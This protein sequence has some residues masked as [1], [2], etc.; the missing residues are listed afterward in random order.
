MLGTGPKYLKSFS[1]SLHLKSRGVLN[2]FFEKRGFLKDMSYN[3]YRKIL[4]LQEVAS[5][6]VE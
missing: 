5:G 4:L 3:E 6:T 1:E 2:K